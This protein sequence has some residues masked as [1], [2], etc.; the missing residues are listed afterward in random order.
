MEKLLTIRTKE[1]LNVLY[2][3]LKNKDFIAVD[4]ETTGVHYD[5]KVIGFSV[6]AEINIAFYVV[7][8]YWDPSVKMLKDLID[9]A[10]AKKV[11]ELLKTKNLIMHNSVFDCSKIL[12]NF[13][14]SLIDNVHTDTV[15]LAHLL[16]ENRKVG[17][18]EL[19]QFYFGDSAKLEQQEMKASVIKNG[20]KATNDSFEIYK[21]DS[22]LLAKYG[23]KDA[24]LTLKLFYLMVEELEKQDLFDFFYNKESM[25]LMRTAT[26]Q[27]NTIGLKV[28]QE[29]LQNLRGELETEILEAEAY[30]QNA[31]KPLIEEKYKKG[32]NLN[33]PQQLSWLLFEKLGNVFG[34]LTDSGRELCHVLDFK[35]P[36]NNKAKRDFV[37]L[38][39][40]NLGLVYGT[41]DTGRPK[42]VQ[43]FYKYTSVDD[44][45]LESLSGRYTWVK[46]LLEYK[47]NT[48]ILNT[49][50]IGIQDRTQ[51]GIIRPSFL[52]HGTTSGRYS[53]KNPNFQNLPK[54]NKK[55]KRCI[56]ARPGRVFI[57]ADYSQLEPRV[58]A[59]I[60]KD[61][62]MIDAFSKGKDFYAVVGMPIFDIQDA[63]PFKGQIDSFDIKYSKERDIAKQFAL[64]TAY[65]TT[66]FR[67]AQELDKSTAECQEIIDKY[68]E[69]FPSV[70]LMML[71]SHELVKKDGVVY[72]LY[73]RPRRIPEALKINDM[74]GMLNHNEL[75]YNVRNM[76]N[77]SMNH[78]VQSSAAS[79]VNRA[80]IAFVNKIKELNIQFCHIVVQVHDEIVVECLEEDASTVAQLLKHAME[81]TTLLPGVALKAD[82]KIGKTLADIK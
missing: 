71:E 66:A 48:K 52:Q 40:N 58:F 19:G 41:S 3:Y 18:K 47:K 5:A 28:D 26:W 24:L 4:T 68:F 6:A 31:I 73:G 79:I 59:S 10:E 42:K 60:S 22:E 74:Y 75:P 9:S 20:G 44:E 7:L 34:T 39:K 23:A 80:C 35:I 29:A 17:L 21:A 33:A 77:L 53:S 76:L 63:S 36:Y 43:E 38:C 11:F 55:L 72:S 45:V 8:S 69:N 62:Q 61:Q 82:P 14:V 37:E 16:N 57:G 46:R 70:E 13:K 12:H 78:R 81:N 50:V 2:D 67:Q 25:P 49:Y 1:E 30:I 56:T 32:F 15:E 27:L 51:Y 65:G 64:A 54:N